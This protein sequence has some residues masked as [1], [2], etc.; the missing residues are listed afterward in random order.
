M[1]RSSSSV[2]TAP[3]PPGGLYSLQSVLS[4]ETISGTEKL[5]AMERRLASGATTAGE[6]HTFAANGR[7]SGVLIRGGGLEHKPYPSRSSSGFDATGLLHVDRVTLL[8]TVRGS[9]QGRNVTQI[10]EPAGSNGISLFTPAWGPVTPPA[11]GSLE[12][13]CP[14]FHRRHPTRS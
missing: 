10:N 1:A 9:G 7:P 13:S 6:A 4:N 8:G 5:T 2:L 3:L 11:P 12:L 14:P